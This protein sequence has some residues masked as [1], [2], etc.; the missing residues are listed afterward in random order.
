MAKQT[1]NQIKSY[2]QKYDKPT[3]Q[4]FAHLFDSIA[5]KSGSN[6]LTGSLIISGSTSDNANGE[7]VDLNVMGNITSSGN[8]SASGNIIANTFTISGNISSSGDLEVRNITASGNISASGNIMGDNFVLPPLGRL[9]L[10]GPLTGSSTYISAQSP[11]SGFMQF[12]VN[13][14]QRMTILPQG[15]I[16]MFN[17]NLLNVVGANMFAS[18]TGS[19]S[20]LNI[21]GSSAYPGGHITASGNISSSGDLEVRNITASGNII[22]L[23]NSVGTLGST[24]KQWSDL[25]LGQDAVINFDNGD[26]TIRHVA[27]LRSILTFEGADTRVE[28]LEIMNSSGYITLSG[29]GEDMIIASQGDMY[30]NPT[31]SN[32]I[33][34]GN[35]SASGDLGVRNIT[36]SGNISMSGRLM[37]TSMLIGTGINNHIGGNVMGAESNKVNFFQPVTASII[38]A[39]GNIIGLSGDFNFVSCSGRITGESFHLPTILGG[40]SVVDIV[41]SDGVNGYGDKLVYSINTRRGEV[42][43]QTQTA[44]AADS[45][46]VIELR[47]SSILANSLIVANVISGSDGGILSGSVISANVVAAATASLN[48]FNIGASIVD[49]ATFTASFAIF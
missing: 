20:G 30:M 27:D 44:I 24:S 49:N 39:S 14:G 21:S 42:R 16:R 18:G 40:D 17:I 3:E 38:S 29:S 13:S 4:Q 9:Q 32:V 26:A 12:V 43:S 37:A 5:F 6:G 47:N 15:E 34:D 41:A 10:A 33:I 31:G 2:F 11:P 1:K 36:A 25:F 46:W 48:F 45:G 23:L 7:P 8:I 19:F 28:K 35:V 22:P